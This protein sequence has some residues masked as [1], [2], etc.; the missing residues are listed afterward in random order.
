MED[1]G[2]NHFRYISGVFCRPRI[3]LTTGR[4]SDL[5]IHN[6]VHRTAGGVSAGIGHLESFHYH[7]LSCERSIS[8]TDDGHHKITG[9]IIPPGLTGSN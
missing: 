6:D 9:A 5:I 1:W 7:T 8:M 4:K 3:I 2:L